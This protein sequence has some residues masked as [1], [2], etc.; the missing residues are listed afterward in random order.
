MVNKD[1]KDDNTIPLTKGNNNPN[2]VKV[3]LADSFRDRSLMVFDSHSRVDTNGMAFLDSLFSSTNHK[4]YRYSF[5]GEGPPHSET[6]KSAISSCASMIVTLSEGLAESHTAMWVGYEVGT[7]HDLEK[8]IIVFENY[9]ENWINLPIP[10]ADAYIQRPGRL[11]NFSDPFKTVAENA[12]MKFRGEGL[13]E[14]SI[15]ANDLECPNPKCKSKYYAVIYKT[16]FLC[17]V[18][19]KSITLES[20]KLQQTLSSI[21]RID[22][23]ALSKELYKFSHK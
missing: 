14:G 7:A 23:E 2:M 22:F 6:I 10:Y 17:P 12:G 15:W 8:N 18:C 3:K 13:P 16:P 21:S 11:R 19:R 5:T 1:S 20:L 9:E 4:R